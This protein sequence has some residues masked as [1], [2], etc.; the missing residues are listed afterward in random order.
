MTKKKWGLQESGEFVEIAPDQMKDLEPQELGSYY[1]DLNK[2]RD[3]E[4]RKLIEQNKTEYDKGVAEK[5]EELRGNLLE[6]IAE[7]QKVIEQ[8]GLE[9]RKNRPQRIITAKDFFEQNKA[10]LMEVVH[11][12]RNQLYVPKADTLRSFVQDS[13][14]EFNIQ[15]IGQVQ[16]R[17]NIFYDL[18]PKVPVGAN[19]GGV[20]TYYD[21]DS[22]NLTRSADVIAEKGSYT[23]SQI[24]WQW[25]SLPLVKI[26]DL[27]PFSV[28]FEQDMARFAAELQLFLR[29]NVDTVVDTQLY[30]GSGGGSPT[31]MTGVYTKADTYTAAAAG[32][33]NPNLAD[34]LV[35]IR[36]NIING[37]KYQP[38]MVALSPT[39]FKKTKWVK[40][41]NGNYTTPPFMDA[42]GKVI[43]GLQVIESA[44]VTAN[45]CLVGDSRFATI[46]EV[47]G[48]TIEQGYQSGDWEL[49]IPSIKVRR[50]LCLVVKNVNAGAFNKCTDIDAALVTLGT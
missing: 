44:A 36:A 37:T 43:D 13:T 5:I 21:Q 17:E 38:D 48:Y 49:D 40:D 30:S 45:T 19:S 28:E 22:E 16:T 10:Q 9:M 15:E 8:Q 24:K 41:S 4:L 23:E 6:S 14:M 50:R 35:D 3:G 47:E 29:T 34:L 33:D 11:G 26:G 46:Y 32:V 20:V 18:F 2:H 1:N 39:D 25:H 42:S 27:L 12:K 31:Q 7:Q